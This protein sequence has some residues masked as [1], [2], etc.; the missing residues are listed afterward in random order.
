[1]ESAKLTPGYYRMVS[2]NGSVMFKPE[3][4]KEV[5]KLMEEEEDKALGVCAN[6]P[7]L[8]NCADPVPDDCPIND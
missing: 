4:R 2:S 8:G 6:C 5:F 3:D 7:H 1:M